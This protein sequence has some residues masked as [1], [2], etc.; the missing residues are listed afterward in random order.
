MGGLPDLYDISN[1]NAGLGAFSLMAAGAWGARAG[2]IPGATPVAPDAWTHL[3]LGWSTPRYPTP[4][5]T[6]TLTSPRSDPSSAVL[7]INSSLNSSEY[8]LVENRPPVGWDAGMSQLLSGTWQGGLLIQHIDSSIGDQ[9]DNSFNKF[10]AGRHQR[11]VV[12]QPSAAQYNLLQ[13]DDSSGCPS[14]LYYKGN[15]DTFD[16]SSNPAS[17]YY[18]GAQSGIL[19]QNI[20]VSGPNMTPTITEPSP[21][22]PH[23]HNHQPQD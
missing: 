14:L 19:V 10:V 12:V 7:L 4:G 20:S 18:S 5:T 2:E 1:T 13:S 16:Q 15:S 9:N 22:H 8:W 3:Y 21:P 11:N 17:T 23:R 6:V